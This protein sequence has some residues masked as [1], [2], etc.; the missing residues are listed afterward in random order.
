ML[1]QWIH[2]VEMAETV[3]EG[4]LLLRILSL[5]LYRLYTFLTLYWAINL[6]FDSASWALGF[7]SSQTE[8]LQLSSLFLLAVLFPFS[9]WD[10]FE[11]MK[12]I[13]GRLRA[14]QGSRMVSGLFATSLI[15]AVLFAFTPSPAEGEK[16]WGVLGLSPIIWVVSACTSV[17]FLWSL[18]Y[19]A[20]RQKLPVPSNTD[21]WVKV[22]LVL[23]GCN[24]V[25]AF[26]LFLA[27][28]VPLAYVQSLLLGLNVIV[29]GAIAWALVRLRAAPSET[30]AAPQ[31]ASL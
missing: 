14:V 15:A 7:E 20:K 30:S 22:L 31:Q 11:E 2:W 16:N 23:F 6:I 18:R 1:L 29:I 4:L 13:I 8:T 17:L 12:P 21:L 25:S 26:G 27:P 10:S 28:L 24:I 5:R 3:V 19:F 9:A